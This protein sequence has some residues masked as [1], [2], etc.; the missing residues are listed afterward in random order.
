[1]VKKIN[2]L[3]SCIT[4]LNKTL[5]FTKAAKVNEVDKLQENKKIKLCLVLKQ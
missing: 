5:V 2:F 3:F 1:M 4:V